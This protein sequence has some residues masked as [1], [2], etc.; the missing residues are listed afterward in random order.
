MISIDTG[1]VFYKYTYHSIL[2][3]SFIGNLK[4]GQDP[5]PKT[6]CEHRF[7]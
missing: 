1:C 5:F 4:S 7:F 2:R 6:N 3:E